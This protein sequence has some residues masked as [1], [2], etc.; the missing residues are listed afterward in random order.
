MCTF[1]LKFQLGNQHVYYALWNALSS[2]KVIYITRQKY[3]VEQLPTP[4]FMKHGET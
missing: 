3:E 2:Y 1:F 4:S